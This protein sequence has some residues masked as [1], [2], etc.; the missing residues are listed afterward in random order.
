MFSEVCKCDDVCVDGSSPGRETRVLQGNSVFDQVAPGCKPFATQT[1][2]GV[3]IYPKP[4][5]RELSVEARTWCCSE[6]VV[7]LASPLC[8]RVDDGAEAD[9][10]LKDQKDAL[11]SICNLLFQNQCLIQGAGVQGQSVKVGIV[12]K[13]I[14]PV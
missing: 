8:L 11:D 10:K 7:F 1:A 14:L 12:T 9:L 6:N 4:E 13:N 3:F 2:R 5:D